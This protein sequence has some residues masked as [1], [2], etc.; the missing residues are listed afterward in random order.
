MAHIGQEGAFGTIGGFG[1]FFGV[2]EFRPTLEFGDILQGSDRI[3]FGDR[4]SF[5]NPAF[6]AITA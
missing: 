2:F 1:G 6:Y 5:T 3:I 4:R